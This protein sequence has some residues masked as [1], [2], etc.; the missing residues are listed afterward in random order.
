M[1]LKLIDSINEIANEQPTF[2]GKK[3]SL[4]LL[5]FIF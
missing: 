1:K 2:L 4:V 3:L 5:A